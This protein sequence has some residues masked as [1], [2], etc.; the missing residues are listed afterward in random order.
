MERGLVNFRRALRDVKHGP[1]AIDC[2]CGLII[3]FEVSGI[4][5]SSI[6]NT[7]T[8]PV[9]ANNIFSLGKKTMR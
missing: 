7:L 8:I 4:E 2:V 3:D 1:S 5:S 6:S 9:S